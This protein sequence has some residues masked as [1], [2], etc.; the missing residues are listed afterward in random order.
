MLVCFVQHMSHEAEIR[1]KEAKGV[2]GL[3][4]DIPVAVM[5]AGSNAY[6]KEEVTTESD[7]DMDVILKDFSQLRKA[8][9]KLHISTDDPALKYAEQGTID[10]VL[11]GWDKRGFRTTVFFWTQ[12]AFENVINLTS[13]TIKTFR[14]YSS[15]K[16]LPIEVLTSLYGKGLEGKCHRNKVE[17]GMIFIVHPYFEDNHEIYLGPQAAMLLLSPKPLVQHGNY[18][19][20]ELHNFRKTLSKKVKVLYKAKKDSSYS[21]IK[22][23]PERIVTKIPPE[24]RKELDHLIKGSI[25]SSSFT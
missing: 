22:V 18:L 10:N 9:E 13:Q 8:C 15:E 6:N 7:L 20:R 23:F 21:L 1:I 24:L 5:Y 2:A 11:F 16:P 25:G 17:D 19:D 4:G 14:T 3:L 12:R